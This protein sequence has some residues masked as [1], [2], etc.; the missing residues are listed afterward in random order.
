MKELDEIRNEIEQALESLENSV[1]SIDRKDYSQRARIIKKCEAQVEN[2][3]NMIETYASEIQ[4]LERN[5][6]IPHKEVHR[7][8]HGRLSGIKQN[9]DLKKKERETEGTLQ[10][11][12]IRRK[13]ND[14][15]D[16]SKSIE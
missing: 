7:K 16:S 6:A 5:K 9:L 10:G 4:Q 13:I 8:L 14:E 1:Q 11:E 2:I 12:I 3:G 15:V